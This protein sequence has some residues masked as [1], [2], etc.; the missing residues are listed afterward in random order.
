MLVIIDPFCYT[1]NT[2]NEEPALGLHPLNDC[3]LVELH[4]SHKNF[5]TKEGKYDTRTEGIV[6]AT[7]RSRPQDPTQFDPSFLV[8]RRIHFE[9][10]HEGA[11]IKRNGK[12]YSFIKIEDIRGYED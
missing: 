7:H 5:T 4:Q 12:I 8:G 10:F 2:M 6:M 9:E 11:R 1:D 3:V